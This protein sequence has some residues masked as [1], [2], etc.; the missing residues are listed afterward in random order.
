MSLDF[1]QLYEELRQWAGS[2]GI[3][4]R[5]ETLRADQAGVFDGVTF[6]MN[7]DYP[8]DERV[9]YLI[10]ALGSIVRRS[11]SPDAVQAMFDDLRDAKP[12]KDSTPDRLDRAIEQY[13]LFEIESSEFAVEL[14]RELGYPDV[15]DAYTNFMSADLDALTEFHR[16]G[17]APVWREF[18]AQWNEDVTAGRRHVI[19]YAP[20]VIPAFTPTR[21]ETQEILQEQG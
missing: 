6:R 4:V 17:H 15:I 9:Y 19:P 21:M 11:L 8:I 1:E 14:L 12:S 20:K 13:R 2:R 18:F 5:D 3:E 7:R 16:T 10:H